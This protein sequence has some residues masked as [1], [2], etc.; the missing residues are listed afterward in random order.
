MAIYVQV[1]SDMGKFFT[2][3]AVIKFLLCTLL[4][5]VNSYSEICSHV[6]NSIK[7]LLL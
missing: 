4:H 6:F 7:S 3:W 2:S 1:P 5:T